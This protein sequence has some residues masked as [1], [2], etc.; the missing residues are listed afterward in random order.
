MY[1]V[2]QHVLPKYTLEYEILSEDRTWFTMIHNDTETV[3]GAGDAHQ[4]DYSDD[5][6][7][8]IDLVISPRYSIL[9][10]MVPP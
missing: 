8:D 3:R 2:F 9:N 6:E 4:Y 10:Q 1:E 7:D 5:G